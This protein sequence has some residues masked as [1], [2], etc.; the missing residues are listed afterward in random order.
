MGEVG[1]G[2]ASDSLLIHLFIYFEERCS[3]HPG[4]QGPQ[5]AQH[6]SGECADAAEALRARARPTWCRPPT[7]HPEEEWTAPEQE[8]KPDSE[9]GF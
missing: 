5:A 7:G 2:N 1:T 3:C 4:D 8:V 6:R 9:T